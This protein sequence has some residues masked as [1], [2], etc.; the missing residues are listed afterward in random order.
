MWVALQTHRHN[1]VSTVVHRALLVTCA[2]RDDL[3]EL[4]QTIQ[5]WLNE[6]DQYMLS[7]SVTTTPELH[8]GYSTL[9]ILPCG[10]G[11]ARDVETAH[12]ELIRSAVAWMKLSDGY[13]DWVHL[14]YGSELAELTSVNEPSVLA[15]SG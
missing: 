1:S 6:D 13:Y 12:L 10:G 5:A 4:H 3:A 2:C 8:N 11:W 15:H 14:L 9:T 7:A